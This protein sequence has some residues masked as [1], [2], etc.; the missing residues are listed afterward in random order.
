[1][2]KHSGTKENEKRKLDY[3]SPGKDVLSYHIQGNEF[4]LQQKKW[5]K[6]SICIEM[7]STQRMAKNVN[8]RV[9]SDQ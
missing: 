5:E 9:L 2:K 8:T 4:D 1:M 6:G 7:M 3:V